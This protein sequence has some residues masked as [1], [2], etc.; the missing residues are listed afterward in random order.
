MP[1][2]WFLPQDE[3]PRHSRATLLAPYDHGGAAHGSK[4]DAHDTSPLFG[5]KRAV[6]HTSLGAAPFSGA[7]QSHHQLHGALASDGPATPREVTTETDGPKTGGRVYYS[8]IVDGIHCHRYSASMVHRLHPAGLVLIT[9]AMAA[10]GLPPG[11]HQL[12]TMAVDIFDGKSDGGKYDG[13]HAVIA[14]TDTLAGA[15][16][17]LDGCVCPQRLQPSLAPPCPP[18]SFVVVSNM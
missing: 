8:L 12:G 10:M 9:D 17:P 7:R 16:L 18:L 6:G 4:L 1:F 15:L 13:L 11:R 14:G 2:V 5:P 3:A